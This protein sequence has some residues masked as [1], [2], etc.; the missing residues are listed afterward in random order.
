MNIKENYR[1]LDLMHGNG[2]VSGISSCE[3]YKTTRH[4]LNINTYS[5]S[6]NKFISNNNANAISLPL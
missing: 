3:R 2:E 1:E 5:D 6:N 4:Y